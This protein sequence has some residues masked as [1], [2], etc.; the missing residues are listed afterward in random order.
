MM[1]QII[2]P[3]FIVGGL[4]L[5]LGGLLGVANRYLKVEIDPRIEELTEMLPGYNCSYVP[6]P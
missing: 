5:I 4:G 1:G 3:M 6:I 2:V